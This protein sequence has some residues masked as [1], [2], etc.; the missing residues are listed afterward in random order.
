MLSLGITLLAMGTIFICMA[1]NRHM[2]ALAIVSVA[3][4]A[5][6]ASLL[7]YYLAPSLSDVTYLVG[8][9]E[10]SIYAFVLISLVILRRFTIPIGHRIDQIYFGLGLFFLLAILIGLARNGSPAILMGRELVFPIATYFLFRFINPDK[11]I[12]RSIVLFILGIASVAAVFAIIE[13]IYVDLINPRFWY[14]VRISGYLEQKYGRFDDPYPGSWIN[15]LPVFIGLPPTFRSIGLMLDPLATAHFLSC[16]FALALFWLRG[17]TKYFLTGLIGLGVVMT[18]SKAGLLLCFLAVGSQALKIRRPLLR[19]SILGVIASIVG[20]IGLSMLSTGD[21]AFTHAGS[22]RTGLYTLLNDPLGHGVGSTGYFA[23]LVTG[24]A[25]IGAAVDTTFS[26]YVY[27]MGVPGLVALLLLVGVPTFYYLRHLTRQ[28]RTRGKVDPLT[29]SCV[30]IFG[31]YTFLSFASAAAFTAVPVFVPMVLLASQVSLE[32]REA[33]RVPA[34]PQPALL[35]E[36]S[37]L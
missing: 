30:M 3:L 5:N 31:S 33:R 14:D 35:P 29:M 37:P 6:F 4:L 36:R 34:L 8:A 20:V 23:F 2:F 27:Q 18:F 19:W 17:M 9:R 16:S 21:D 26:V 24:E 1:F 28:R 22:F 10:L 12:I 11:Q 7:V 13:F 25:S 15:Y 32:V